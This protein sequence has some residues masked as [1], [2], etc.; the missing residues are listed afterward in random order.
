[1]RA[2]VFGYHEIGYVCFEEL[3][4]SGVEVLCLFTHEDDPEEEIW[5]RKP[6]ALAVV[7][8]IPVYKPD[9]LKDE[10]WVSLIREMVPD[11]IFSFY[12]RNMIPKAILDIP[13]IGAFNLHGSLLPRYRGRNPVN[14]VLIKGEKKTGLTLHYMVEKPDAG[15]IVARKEVTIEF[16]D[17]AYTLF[18]KIAKE[19]R[20]LIREIL[21][22]LENGTFTRIPQEVLGI[23]S[24]FG[25]RKPEDGLILWHNDA[26]SI[27]NLVRAVTHPYPGA[28]TYL[29]GKRLY[30][31]KAYPEE[32]SREDTSPGTVI[33]KKPLLVSTGKGVLKLINIQIEGEDEMDGEKFATIYEIEGKQLGGQS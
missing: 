33:S 3:I 4:N 5:F 25:G 14:W 8:N 20:V 23:S 28:F 31:W 16:D 21:P 30:I 10:K 12:Y 11:I 7:H 17:T 19:A 1:M 15:D 18:M 6:E 22:E 32:E 2:V 24:Y 9:S 27:Y 13:D 26:L 29:D